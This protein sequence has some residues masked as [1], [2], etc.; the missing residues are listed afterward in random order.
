V[1][2]AIA[3]LLLGALAVMLQGAA[4]GFAPPRWIPDLGFLVVVAL[5]PRWRSAAG[6]LVLA[7]LIGYIA[8]LLSGSLLG[9]HTLLRLIAF[10]AARV[11]SRSLNLRGTLPQAVF[12]GILTLVDALGAAVLTA[13]LAPP[14]LGFGLPAPGALLTHAGVNAAFAPLAAW[15]T[16]RV[17]ALV[18]DED[19]GRRLLRF[20]PRRTA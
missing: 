9:Q 6:G 8:D 5:A 10:A 19:A 16:D 14:A 1:K 2:P 15:V 7:A 12:V 3:L 18:S 13:F 20:A 17:L 11:A 4:G